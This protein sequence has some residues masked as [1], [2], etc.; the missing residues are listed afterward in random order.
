MTKD[1]WIAE[2]VKHL[3]VFLRPGMGRRYAATVAAIEWVTH[4]DED[5]AEAAARWAE[6]RP[7]LS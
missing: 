1:A 4:R 2:F 3:V 5:P 6:Q 7:P